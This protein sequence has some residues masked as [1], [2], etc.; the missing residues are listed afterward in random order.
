MATASRSALGLFIAAVVL[1]L[2]VPKTIR[3]AGLLNPASQETGD[4]A[5]EL[6]SLICF[7]TVSPTGRGSLS[8][9]ALPRV[10]SFLQSVCPSAASTGTAVMESGPETGRRHIHAVAC[11]SIDAVL[12]R[13]DP[14]GLHGYTAEDVPRLI[15][16]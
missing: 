13:A 3:A 15:M 10:A 7:I 4:G 16:Q 5:D 14:G 11:V 6:D 8:E 12:Q 1:L 9:A 2:C